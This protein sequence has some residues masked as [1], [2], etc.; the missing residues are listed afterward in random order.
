[1]FIWDRDTPLDFDGHG[2]HVSGTIGQLTNDNTGTAGVAFN[3]K[4]MP[5]KVLDSVWDDLFGSPH[6]ATDDVVAQG[7]RYAADNGANIINMS[8]GRQSPPNC[9]TNRNQPGCAVVIE[10]AI[11][12]AVGKGVFIVISAG[13]DGE[14][15]THP[16]ST[17]AE[18]ASRVAGAVSVAAVDRRTVANIATGCK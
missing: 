8:L 1:D 5:V 12:Y 3:V 14:D 11:N 18:I 10:D 4:L 16:V 6:Q 15:T 9:G 7:I 13:N 17:P 2:T